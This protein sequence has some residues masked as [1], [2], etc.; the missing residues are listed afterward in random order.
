MALYITVR[1]NDFCQKGD[2]LEDVGSG[3]VQKVTML[4]DNG[5]HVPMDHF[6]LAFPIREVRDQV[7][8]IQSRGLDRCALKSIMS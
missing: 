3:L 1:N 2:Y 4:P 6:G 7:I 5:R 8:R